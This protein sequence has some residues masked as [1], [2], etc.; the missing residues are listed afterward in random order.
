MS[1]QIENLI[2]GYLDGTLTEKQ[3]G[4]LAQW[5]EAE[6]QNANVFAEAVFLD[7]RMHAEI[8]VAP[9]KDQQNLDIGKGQ[10]PGDNL[11]QTASP[12]STNSWIAQRW[13][14]IAI[15]IAACIL[16][17][18]GINLRPSQKN[19]STS[20]GNGLPTEPTFASVAQIVDADGGGTKLRIGERLSAQT[21]QLH[22]GFMRL[23]FDD[24]VEVTLQGPAEY[25]LVAA[26]KTLLKSGLLTANVPPGAEGFVVDTPNA[27]VVDLGTSFGVDLT[28]KSTTL[29]SVFDGEVEVSDSNEKRL[30][31]EGESVRIETGKQIESVEMN[32]ESFAKVWPISTGIESSTETFQY[33]HPWP[34]N[35]RFVQSNDLIYL[36]PD[37]YGVELNAPVRVNISEAGKYS[38]ERDLTPTE[39]LA[40]Q[41]IRSFMIFFH[42]KKDGPLRFQ[43]RISGSITFDSP[44]LG[45]IVLDEELDATARRFTRFGP[46]EVRKGHQLELT[47]QDDTD[48]VELSDDRKTLTLSLTTPA[49]FAEF[50]RVIVDASHPSTARSE[51]RSNTGE[52]SR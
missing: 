15:A 16:V 36:S 39:L 2:G 21:I 46:R 3:L 19:P 30:L 14:L 18:I 28:D 40:G 23:A 42:P 45:V 29:V 13:P 10:T 20:G 31:K 27:E 49:R 41:R 38:N 8:N 17:A 22:S 12:R 43:R 11:H 6:P 51:S 24:G 25:E 1:Q 5:I 48:V 34:R 9:Y 50:L 33:V 26:G 7:D 32:P 44:V 52:R 35:F 37:S 47:G 4:S